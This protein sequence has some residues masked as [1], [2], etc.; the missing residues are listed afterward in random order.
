MLTNKKIKPSI[1]N[2]MNTDSKLQGRVFLNDLP[3]FQNRICKR[4]FSYEE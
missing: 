4:G 2:N 3:E 1:L